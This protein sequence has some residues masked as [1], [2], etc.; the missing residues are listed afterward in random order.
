MGN[1]SRQRNKDVKWKGGG[2]FSPAC[3]KEPGQSV[4]VQPMVT[5]CYD[6][7]K[8]PVGK[9]IRSGKRSSEG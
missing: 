5:D 7:A 1:F 2:V 4:A 3:I 6:K 9:Q 8:S